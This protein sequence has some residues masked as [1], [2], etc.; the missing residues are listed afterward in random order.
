MATKTKDLN[1]VLSYSLPMIIRNFNSMLKINLEGGLI[2]HLTSMMTIPTA[3]T[4]TTTRIIIKMIITIDRMSLL[5]TKIK[6]MII[7]MVPIT[8][9]LT[10]GNK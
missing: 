3:K 4:T 8:T 5:P 1:L 10:I 9:P 2:T 7:Q 6:I